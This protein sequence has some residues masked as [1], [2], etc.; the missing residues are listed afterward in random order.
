MKVVVIGNS[1]AAHTFVTNLL[2]LADSV[3]IEIYGEEARLPYYRTRI[4]SLLDSQAD[5]DSLTIRPVI[6]DSRVRQY[7]LHVDN[8]DPDAKLI[9]ASDGKAHEYDVLV[10]AN[11]ARASRLPLPGGRSDGIFALRTVDDVHQLAFWLDRHSGPVAV[12]GGG[13][14]GLEAAS[15]ISRYISREVTVLESADYLLPRQLDSESARYLQKRLSSMNIKV[16][17]S[18]K[19]SNF[20][21]SK[22]EVSAIKCDDGFTIPA[23]TVIES[24]G[25]SPNTFLAVDAGLNVGR[26]V[27]VDEFMRT[28]SPDIYAI[29]DVAQIDGQVRGTA[30]VAMDSAKTLASVLSGQQKAYKAASQSSILKAAGLDVINIGNPFLK[31]TECTVIEDETRREAWFTAGGSL[32]AAVLI[33]SRANFSVAM[34]GLGRPFEEIMAKLK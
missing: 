24:V 23:Q 9:Y 33:G 25:I 22:G 19:T 8:I 10:L 14:L 18:A 34:S 20:L 5:P 30:A 16:L 11:G 27:I 6:S 4:L 1:I 15:E 21:S 29:G 2:K 17:C 3:E 28:S 7:N 26:G 13:L 31:G 12:I 32:T